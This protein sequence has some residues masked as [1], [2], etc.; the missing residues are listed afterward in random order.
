MN[1]KYYIAN[2]TIQ[3]KGLFASK[4][5]LEGEIILTVT[6]NTISKEEFQKEVENGNILLLEFDDGRGIDISQHDSRFINHSCKPNTQFLDSLDSSEIM[7]IKAIKSIQNEEEL[8][9][10]YNWDWSKIVG[11]CNC[12]Y[13]K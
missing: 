13:C 8:T 12:G 3:G 2:S 1:K 7:L 10:N 4:T 5:I 11:G 9:F 6:G